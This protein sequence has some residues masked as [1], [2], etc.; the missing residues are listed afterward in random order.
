MA[1]K[2]DHPEHYGGKGNPY[3]AI[4][5]ITQ[6]LSVEGA[7]QFCLGNTLKYICRAGKKGGNSMQDDLGKAR[8]Y[9]DYALSLSE[10][11]HR[12]K[13]LEEHDREA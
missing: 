13:E 3:E 4:R 8:W 9:L 1:E 7:L 2:I 5:V 12:N 6:W 11:I 10:A